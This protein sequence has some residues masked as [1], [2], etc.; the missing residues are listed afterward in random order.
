MQED[1]VE[2]RERI[3]EIR[4]NN[5]D[6]P[7]EARLRDDEN[8]MLQSSPRI[9]QYA[10]EQW[11]RA[12]G[13]AAHSHSLDIGGFHLIFF[14]FDRDGL[15]DGEMA[16][17]E[18]EI[19]ENKELPTLLFFHVPLPVATLIPEV[20]EKLG[21]DLCLA[22]GPNTDRLFSLLSGNRQVLAAFCGHI[23][24]DSMHRYEDFTQITT[25]PVFETRFRRVV[26]RGPG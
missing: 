13:P 18:M 25:G 11:A 20:V 22:A 1:F 5:V 4:R 10:R 12:F 16:W 3:K 9:T 24:F 17:L 15:A 26:V 21:R 2:E 8:G 23:H 14:N 19:N 6:V 7:S